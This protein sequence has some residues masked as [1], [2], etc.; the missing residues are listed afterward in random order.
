MDIAGLPNSRQVLLIKSA[1]KITMFSRNWDHNHDLSTK[2]GRRQ[3]ER[4]LFPARPKNAMFRRGVFLIYT[5][6]ALESCW[7]WRNIASCVSY[8]VHTQFHNSNS[9]R[10]SCTRKSCLSACRDVLDRQA[11][12][13]L[14]PF[15]LPRMRQ[16]ASGKVTF[17]IQLNLLE[18]E[19]W[20]LVCG[21]ICPF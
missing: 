19:L 8:R 2:T 18:L 20:N 15:R 3:A 6:P 17:S 14:L 11:E 4:Q 7:W 21:L 13:N 10:F 5:F 12:W 16:T 1:D 9:N